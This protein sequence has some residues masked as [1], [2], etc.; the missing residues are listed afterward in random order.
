MATEGSHRLRPRPVPALDHQSAAPATPA[1][2]S[3]SATARTSSP[4]SACAATSGS[5]YS[6]YDG[7]TWTAASD[8]DIDHLV[9]LAEAWDSGASGWTTAQRQAFAND[10]TRP[11]LIAVTDNVNQS[12]GDQDPAEWMPLA[13]RVPL[14]LRPRLGPGEA[15]L[16]PHRRLGG[17]ERAAARSSAAADQLPPDHRPDR[18]RTCP[19]RLRTDLRRSVPYGATEEGDHD[20]RAAPGTTAEVRRRARPR[21]SGSRRAGPC[22]AEVRCA[23]GAGGA[24]RTLQIAGHHYALIPVDRP[25]PG[26]RDARTRCCWTATQVWPLPDSPFPPTAIRTPRRTPPT[27]EPVRVAFGSC[28][29]A[30]PPADASKDPVGPDALDTLAARIA[31]DP[32]GERPDVL[33]L[34]G[35]QVYADETSEATRRWLAARR[36]LREAAGRP[37]RGLR[38]VHPPLL[39][40][41]ARPRGPLAAVHRAQLHDLRRPRR[42]RRLEHQRGLARRHAGHARGGASGC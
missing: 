1:R 41:L 15:L 22:T 24:A 26:H 25:A 40:V 13:H 32:D 9:P 5:W 19:R 2:P 16:R 31:A 29:W 21:P 37:G 36:D 4:D 17:E 42:H 12:K 39:R 23:D 38:G 10:L 33:L 20:G 11:Q 7:A 18:P 14:H 34:L 27:D 8:V 3:S 30:A 28:R 6:A 35:D